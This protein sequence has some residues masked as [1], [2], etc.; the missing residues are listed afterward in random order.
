MHRSGSQWIAVAAFCWAA[1]ALASQD[2]PVTPA[3][4][5]AVVL[6]PAAFLHLGAVL[7]RRTDVMQGYARAIWPSYALFA[8]AGVVAARSALRGPEAAG[9]LGSLG[10]V[11]G[12][13]VGLV[14]AFRVWR[15]RLTASRGTLIAS[16]MLLA[17]S[18]L[19]VAAMLPAVQDAGLLPLAAA[20]PLSGI[21]ALTAA[22]LAARPTAATLEDPDRPSLSVD[23]VARG[24]AHAMRKP[25]F[26]LDED[27]K[28]LAP[29]LDRDDEA[30]I[31][32]SRAL[33]GQLQRLVTDLLRLAD[34]QSAVKP[35]RLSIGKLVEQAA[36]DVRTRFPDAEVETVTSESVIAGDEAALRCVIIN[37]LENALEAAE[38]AAW[39]RIS[40]SGDGA[41]VRL[42]VLDRS[43]G[44]P[45][46]IRKHLFEPFQSTKATG[47][48]LGLATVR[49]IT[50][51][52]G[53]RVCLEEA[54]N[55][56][57]VV[58]TLPGDGL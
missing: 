15:T 11:S 53:G 54:P 27:L 29:R 30:K 51:A 43:G 23:Q 13:L 34:G 8:A 31:E 16:G 26:V 50:E 4:I 38:R 35:R 22:S 52:H 56:S 9:L 58:I 39:V 10:V 55:G 47:T 1:V 3:L 19:A 7:P 14:I 44:F 40:T 46:E 49:V 45:P 18:V 48:G 28:S 17:G 5:P 21:A 57:R 41:G 36:S 42:E 25:L 24:I 37:L 12:A 33:L 20:L 32:S 2:W 6:I